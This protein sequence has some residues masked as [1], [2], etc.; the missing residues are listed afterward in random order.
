MVLQFHEKLIAKPEV[1]RIYVVCAFAVM[2]FAAWLPDFGHIIGNQDITISST[3]AFG[4]LN[5]IVLGPFWGAV[6]SFGVLLS[7][8]LMYHPNN[9]NIFT[10]LSPLFVMLSSVIAGLIVIKKEKIA[11]LIYSILI[12]SWYLF[13]TGRTAY[14]QPWFHILALIVFAISYRVVV[15]KAINS[16]MYTS[17]YLFLIS[18]IAIL[19]DHMAGSITAIII[20]D[21]PPQMFNEF[22]FIYP[23]ERIILAVSGAFI[24]FMLIQLEQYIIE[25]KYIV[26]DEVEKTKMGSLREYLQNDVKTILDEER[27]K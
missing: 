24:A 12:L 9:T 2:Y 25:G 14:L 27:K 6:V 15:T 20:L 3:A 1:K 5:G 10:M 23:V 22:L 21:I 4:P 11:L 26:A 17:V 8:H 16:T 18:L 13:D 7:H 19:S